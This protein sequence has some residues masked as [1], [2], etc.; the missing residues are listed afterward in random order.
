V[1]DPINEHAL[2]QRSGEEI[3]KFSKYCGNTIAN[4]FS[5]CAR[6]VGKWGTTL[7]KKLDEDKLR[8]KPWNTNL[9]A[10]FDPF[11][12]CTFAKLLSVIGNALISM[13][14][15]LTTFCPCITCG[16]TY[17]RL[18]NEG[19]MRDWEVVNVQVSIFSSLHTVHLLRVL[20]FVT[21][22]FEYDH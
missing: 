21:K 4:M 12:L 13:P 17:H 5:D 6:V 15:L 2:L 10:C 20:H 11:G 22:L 3:E 19:D 16:K 8:D 9:W 7:Q 18:H 1:P 14:G